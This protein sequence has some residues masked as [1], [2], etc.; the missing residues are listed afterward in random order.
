MGIKEEITKIAVEQGYEGAKPKSIAQAI[1]ALTDTLAGEDVKSGRSVVDAIR[2]YAPY[3]G[4]GGSGRVELFNETVTTEGGSN[5]AMAN[6]AFTGDIDADPL[7]VTFDGTEYE[8]PRSETDG[9]LGKIVTYG[10]P[11][12]ER[13]SISTY[14]LAIRSQLS[15]GWIVYT[16]TAGTYTIV[17]YT[18]SDGSGGGEGITLGPLVGMIAGG[19]KE[20]EEITVYVSTTPYDITSG[21]TYSDVLTPVY[22]NTNVLGTH[23]NIVSISAPSGCY[24]VILATV[25][26]DWTTDSLVVRDAASNQQITSGFE[27]RVFS[28]D[29]YTNALF[30]MQIPANGL[31]VDFGNGLNVGD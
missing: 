24:V 29:Y 17:A 10:T 20:N 22:S 28:G 30:T 27:C 5:Y 9:V 26:N 21:E 1:D 15:G 6:L 13:P 11:F 18:V 31:T 12:T 8:L 4:G 3:V 14:P 7:V 16:E 19:A 25:Q 2:K 23:G